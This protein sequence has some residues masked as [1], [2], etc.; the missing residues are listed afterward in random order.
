[1]ADQHDAA[2]DA[3]DERLEPLQPVE[4]EV[5][6]RLVEQHD[7]EP[8][9]Q[10]RGQADAGGLTAGERR[11]SARSR[12]RR[13]GPGRRARADALVEVGRAAGQ[14]AVQRDGVDVGG[15]PAARRIAERGGRGIHRLRRL[16][17]PGAPGDVVGDGL[18]GTR[19]CSCGSQPTNASRGARAHGAGLRFD[20]RRGGAAASTCP[21]RWRRPRRRRR[22]GRPSGRALR[23]GCG[24]RIRR[25]GPGPRVLRSPGESS[26]G[27]GRRACGS[28]VTGSV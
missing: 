21:R 17:A 14:P 22:P 2:A 6:G 7:V 11:S 24:G 5:V 9:E 1:M 16:G 20:R 4:V 23:T 15:R 13:R 3:A 8:A 26:C 10:Q 27:G 12:A 19:S 25:P 18:A 28:S